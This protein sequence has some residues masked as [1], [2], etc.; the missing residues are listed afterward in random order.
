MSTFLDSLGGPGGL[1]G[2]VASIIGTIGSV[3]AANQAAK[4]RELAIQQQQTTGLQGLE[5]NYIT[6][7]KSLYNEGGA[8]NDALTNTVRNLG[9]NLAAGG[10]YNPSVV[11][12]AAVA[13]QQSLNAGLSGMADT[14]AGQRTQGLSQL[15]Q[16]IGGQRAGLADQNWYNAIQQKQQAEGGLSSFLGA[17][18]QQNLARSGANALRINQPQMNGTSG[19]QGANLPGNRPP[20]EGVGPT[21]SMGGSAIAPPPQTYAPAPLSI[22]P[23]LPT[24][25]II[26]DTLSL[27]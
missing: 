1:F 6:G 8:G 21:Q 27:R 14:L 9:S 13:G 25:R 12:G 16:N 10:V 26:Y 17:L 11:G 15:N 2:G 18:T 7:L 23:T 4:Q 3:N 19:D 5:G 24:K 20:Y 22:N